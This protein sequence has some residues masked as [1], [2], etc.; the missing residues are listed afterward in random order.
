MIHIARI[1][2]ADDALSGLEIG[3]PIYALDSTTIDLCLSLFLWAQFRKTKGAIKINTLVDLHGNIPT[4]LYISDEKLH[5]VNFMDFLLPEA[6]VFYILGRAYLDF[7]RL[8][9]MHLCKSFFYF[10]AKVN[11]SPTA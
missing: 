7:E 6:G 11:S 9:R 3:D 1:L 8:H 10:R 5:N 4:V 2:H